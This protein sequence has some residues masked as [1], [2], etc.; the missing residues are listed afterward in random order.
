MR[1]SINLEVASRG[2]PLDYEVDLPGAGQSKLLGTL[3]VS[4]RFLLLFETACRAEEVSPGG[5][6]ASRPTRVIVWRTNAVIHQL[7]MGSPTKPGSPGM[8]RFIQCR[9]VDRYAVLQNRLGSIEGGN[10]MPVCLSFLCLLF[11]SEFL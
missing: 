5:L 6:V 8:L 1:K 11:S 9:S 7:K 2:L 4:G 3:A 10:K